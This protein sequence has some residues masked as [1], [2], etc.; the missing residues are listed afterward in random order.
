[1]VP[2]TDLRAVRWVEWLGA[3]YPK[4]AHEQRG[5]LLFAQFVIGKK[6]AQCQQA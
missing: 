1:M 2:V 6:G 3:E 4:V 5:E